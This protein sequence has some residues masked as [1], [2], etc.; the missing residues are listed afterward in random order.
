[1]GTLIA[2]AVFLVLNRHTS[3]NETTGHDY[4]GIQELD[5]PLPMWWVGMFMLTIGYAIAYLVYYPGLGNIDGTAGWTSLDQWQQEVDRHEARFA[6]LYAR[7]AAM[8]PDELAQDRTAQQVG[9][10]LFINNCSTCHGITAQGGLGFPDL[11]DGEWIWGSGFDDIKQAVLGGRIGVMP[12][13]GAALGETGVAD[14]TQYTLSL[15]GRD[16]DQAA[17][18]R[19]KAQYDTLCVAC[20]GLAGEGNPMLGAPNLTND[21]WLYGGSE[22]DIAFA[23]RNGRNGN[24]PSFADVLDEQKAHILAGY[25]NT[26]QGRR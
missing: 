20:H 13:W 22:E 26:L 21:L 10:R 16:H 1:M 2:S 4:D 12:P 19:G 18:Q 15:A 3:G 25:V 17:A 7:L 9:R 5:N 24:M 6:P 14:V 23:I 8:T 11:T